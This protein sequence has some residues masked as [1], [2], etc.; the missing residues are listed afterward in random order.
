MGD[1]LLKSEETAVAAARAMIKTFDFAYSILEELSKTIAETTELRINQSDICRLST[2][3]ARLI[4]RHTRSRSYGEARIQRYLYSLFS[5]PDSHMRP[6]GNSYPFVLI[7]LAN[8]EGRAPHICFGILTKLQGEEKTDKDFLECFL[9]WINEEFD[10][11]CRSANKKDY[12]WETEGEIT[13]KTEMSKLRARIQFQN[14]R[15]FDIG[16]EEQLTERANM[17]ANWFTERLR[18]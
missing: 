12:G 14:S 13:G 17:L 7:S 8:K 15:L 6:N 11:I 1:K 18:G 2:Q 10:E 3:D 4:R 5:I 16:N 9:L